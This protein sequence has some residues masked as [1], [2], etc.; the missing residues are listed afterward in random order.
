LIAVV[1]SVV[2][3]LGRR[4]L[5]PFNTRH[6]AIK[7]RILEKLEQRATIDWPDHP[8]MRNDLPGRVT[9]TMAD[10]ICSSRHRQ[11][12][13]PLMTTAH[14]IRRPS[15]NRFNVGRRGTISGGR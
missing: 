6:P 3:R 10:A 9:N 1:P 4:E 7:D 8:R 13:R 14:T 5:E 15:G 2:I 11:L 12:G